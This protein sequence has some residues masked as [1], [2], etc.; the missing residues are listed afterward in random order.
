MQLHKCHCA[1]FKIAGR[2][3]HS[4]A[5]HKFYAV[6]QATSLACR[7]RAEIKIL[8]ASRSKQQPDTRRQTK[9]KAARV[10]FLQVPAKVESTAS[11]GFSLCVLCNCLDLSQRPAPNCML[12]FDTLAKSAAQ[13]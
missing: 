1:T 5:V 6:C 2:S 11:L 9:E 8:A 7:P 3:P 13:P 4:L 12:R 10:A